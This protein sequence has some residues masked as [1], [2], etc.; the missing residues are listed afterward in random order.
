LTTLTVGTKITVLRRQTEWV[1]VRSTANGQ[2]GFI[3]KEFVAPV[4]VARH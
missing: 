3:R 2:T 1:E 4:E